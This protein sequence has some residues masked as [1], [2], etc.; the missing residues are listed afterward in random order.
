MI[1]EKNILPKT[2][3]VPPKIKME[4]PFFPTIHFLRFRCEEKFGASHSDDRRD[5]NK[6]TAR[7]DGTDGAV[8]RKPKG[9]KNVGSASTANGRKSFAKPT[10]H[11]REEGLRVVKVS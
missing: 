5:A 4:G 1:Y 11:N 10:F 9:T 6:M 3:M 8:R 2:K 7:C